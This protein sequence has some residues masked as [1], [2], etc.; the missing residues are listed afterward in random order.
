MVDEENGCWGKFKANFTRP[1]YHGG[2]MVITFKYDLVLKYEGNL[3][4]EKLFYLSNH[5]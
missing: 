1:F 5:F 2:F 3:K 4:F